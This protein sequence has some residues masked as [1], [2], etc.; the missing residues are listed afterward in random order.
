[1]KILIFLIVVTDL[2]VSAEKHRAAVSS[3][4]SCKDLYKRRFS[5]S[6]FACYE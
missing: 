1:M 3:K 6:V 4:P 2:Y 5:A